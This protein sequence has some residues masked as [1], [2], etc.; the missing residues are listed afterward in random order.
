VDANPHKQN[1]YMPGSRIPIVDEK[2]IK[3]TKPDCIL[4][5][6]WNIKEEVAEQLSYTKAWGCKLFV[7]VP[8]FLEI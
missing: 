1:N 2:K 6:P 7:A 4:I 3:E 8:E 5:L